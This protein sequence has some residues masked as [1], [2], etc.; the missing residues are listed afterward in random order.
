MASSRE[1]KVP[2][3]S[4]TTRRGYNGSHRRDREKAIR[5]LHEGDPCPFCG[6]GMYLDQELDFD[7]EVPVALGGKEGPKRLSHAF[8][9]RSAGGKLAAAI[10]GG[11][12]RRAAPPA[13]PPPKP[14]G[15]PCYSCGMLM[16]A[17]QRLKLGPRGFGPGD[18]WSHTRCSIAGVHV[19]PDRV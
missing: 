4:S 19:P 13:P 8:C 9:N 3:G 14:E 12:E 16:L 7:H 11:R 2:G 5:D 18:V 6:N 10:R 15:L 17:G 1:R